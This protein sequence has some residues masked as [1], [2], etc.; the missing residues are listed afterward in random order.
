MEFEI[1]DNLPHQCFLDLTLNIFIF[2]EF[3][4]QFPRRNM[5]G[6]QKFSGFFRKFVE[7]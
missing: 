3:R 6:N 5:G 2:F 4:E 1:H 7:K